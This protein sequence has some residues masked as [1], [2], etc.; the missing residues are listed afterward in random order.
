MATQT[1][2]QR[3]AAAKKAAATRKRNAA[4]RSTS[5]AKASARQDGEVGSPDHSVSDGDRAFGP[6]HDQ[7]GDARDGTPARRGDRTDRGVRTPGAA[8]GAYPDRRGHRGARLRREDRADV[9]EPPARHAP[10]AALR[11]H[12][13][14]DHQAQPRA[15]P[16][17]S[18]RH[19]A[20][21]ARRPARRRAAGRGL[22]FGGGR[23]RRSRARDR[24]GRT[25]GQRRVARRPARRAF[26]A[27]RRPFHKGPVSGM[28]VL[29]RRPDQ[30][31]AVRKR[32]RQDESR[33][34][35]GLGSDTTGSSAKGK[36]DAVDNRRS[37]ARS[38]CFQFR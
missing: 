35:Q 28:I 10:A 36:S 16:P 25:A 23:G 17:A 14:G 18:S 32:L 34:T 8:R 7:A 33:D 6:D 21:R 4:N 15:P 27:F 3:Q 5:A 20:R 13:R 12:R 9:H 1:R 30:V 24:V 22:A 29:A 2:T 37:R 38:C 31:T 26:F 19:R 11:A